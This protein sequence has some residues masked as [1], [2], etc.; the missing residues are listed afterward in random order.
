MVSGSPFP[1]GGMM[2][3]RLNGF[4]PSAARTGG[5]TARRVAATTIMKRPVLEGMFNDR[6][7]ALR[8]HGR[9]RRR[10]VVLLDVPADAIEVALNAGPKVF[11][12]LVTD[13]SESDKLRIGIDISSWR[14]GRI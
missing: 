2:S 11:G 5:V 6:R 10:D 8:H 14:L 9:R 4:C 13:H 1:L 7:P 3:S 12:Q